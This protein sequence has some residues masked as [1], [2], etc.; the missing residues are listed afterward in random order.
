MF[1]EVTDILEE[2]LSKKSYENFILYKKF[3]S[4]FYIFLETLKITPDPTDNF[5]ILSYFLENTSI[6]GDIFPENSKKNISSKLILDFFA[7]RKKYSSVPCFSI[8]KNIYRCKYPLEF[9]ALEVNLNILEDI[10]S[11]KDITKISI[12]NSDIN[13]LIETHFFKLLRYS[14]YTPEYGDSTFFS[15]NGII[16]RIC[17]DG[18]IQF[19]KKNLI[20]R[21]KEMLITKGEYLGNFEVLTKNIDF[22]VIYVNN[23][24]LKTFTPTLLDNHIFQR[25]FITCSKENLSVLNSED[26]SIFNLAIL[27]FISKTLFQLLTK[28][29]NFQINTMENPL[30]LRILDFIDKNIHEKI[31]VKGLEKIFNLNRNS[32]IELFRKN[33]NVYPSTYILNKKLEYGA[34]YLLHTNKKISEIASDLN[35]YNSSFFSRNFKNK[36]FLTPLNFKKT[37]NQL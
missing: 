25:E 23:N 32:I 3:L 19:S 8:L 36:Y 6:Y 12:K 15:K 1:S 37:K 34:L 9:H 16:I 14:T 22:I 20:L 33:L 13:T 30:L 2:N 5:I 28:G 27:K 17:L 29:K 11:S 18:E 7:L 35:F 24:F 26:P 31:T 21:S 10:Y 4:S